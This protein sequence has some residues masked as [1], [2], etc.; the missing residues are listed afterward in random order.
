MSHQI[1]K[2]G[3]ITECTVCFVSVRI[4]S[5]TPNATNT[6]LPKSSRITEC[7]YGLFRLDREKTDQS[8]QAPAQ[9][10]GGGEVTVSGRLLRV[11]MPRQRPG[12]GHILNRALVASRPLQR[13]NGRGGGSRKD[14]CAS[15]G[16]HAGEPSRSRYRLTC[17][18]GI[19][20]LLSLASCLKNV[21]KNRLDFEDIQKPF[22]A[23]R[24]QSCVYITS[25]CSERR[26]TRARE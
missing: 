21:M 2:S 8:A 10:R 20:Y 9:G 17:L 25:G 14:F 11:S 4:G 12:G 24:Q 18:V 16:T 6:D 13:G 1:P 7:M 26:A 19:Q 15:S 5:V 22:T 23:K 3:R